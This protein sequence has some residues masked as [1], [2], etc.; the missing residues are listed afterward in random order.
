M[1]VKSRRNILEANKTFHQ[2]AGADEQNKSENGFGN[3]KA[4]A[5]P[6]AMNTGS[7]T[8]STFVQCFGQLGF[9][10]DQRRYKTEEHSGEDR[11]TKGHRKHTQVEIDLTK[12]W[13]GLPADHAQEIESPDREQHPRSS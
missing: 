6:T 7:R 8:A 3:D 10:A 12:S 1:R 11:N 5:Q 4:V 13:H 9:R 2:Q